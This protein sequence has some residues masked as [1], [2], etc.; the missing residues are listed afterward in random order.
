MHTFSPTV[1][2]GFEKRIVCPDE[3]IWLILFLI[4]M[5]IEE[6]AKK[7]HAYTLQNTENKLFLFPGHFMQISKG[8]QD[9]SELYH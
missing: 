4:Q 7:L 8:K 2:G 9:I 5:E 1:Y 6:K 3:I